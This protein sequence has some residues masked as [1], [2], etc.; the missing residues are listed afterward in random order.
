MAWWG[1]VLIGVASYILGAITMACVAANSI[2]R[3][4]MY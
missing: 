4:D 3:D 1:V 2:I